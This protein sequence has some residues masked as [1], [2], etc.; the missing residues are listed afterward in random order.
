[1]GSISFLNSVIMKK[2]L[3][4]CCLFSI[5]SLF[6]SAQKSNQ[7][8]INWVN[9][10]E[11]DY[12]FT[13]KWDYADPVYL[14][15]YSQLVCDGLCDPEIDNMRDETGKIYEDSLARYYQLVDTTHVYYTIECKTNAYEFAG[16]NNI[17]VKK[18][19]NGVVQCYTLSD[20]GTR[21]TL[22]LTIKGNTC[23]PVIMLRSV[24]FTETLFYDCKKGY[25]KIDK[26]LWD[27]GILKAEFDLIFDNFDKDIWWK[28]KI[29][30]SIN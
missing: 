11:G 20:A 18:H 12:S 8:K 22:N 19:D 9:D 21:S 6:V 27:K 16:A 30:S 5:F 24:S 17:F 4:F 13:E 2:L 10:L 29:Y 14:N 26:Q 3:I 23:K 25:I 15:E 28:G 1:M 7:I